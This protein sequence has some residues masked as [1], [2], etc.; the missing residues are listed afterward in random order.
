[1]LNISARCGIMRKKIKGAILL[2][3][4]E[5]VEVLSM[6]N[7]INEPAKN[8]LP[9]DMIDWDEISEFIIDMLDPKYRGNKGWKVINDTS[10]TSILK[11]NSVIVLKILYNDLYGFFYKLP[12]ERN[13]VWY[14]MEKYIREKYSRLSD[15][16]LSL[17]IRIYH[18]DDR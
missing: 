17:I 6:R 11:E 2:D 13:I 16:A 12:L 5:F 10:A 8:N 4:S 15:E 3:R 18:I 1:M 7:E 14:R 9:N